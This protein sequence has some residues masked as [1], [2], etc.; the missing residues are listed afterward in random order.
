MNTSALLLSLVLASSGNEL[1]VI[2]EPEL[3][4]SGMGAIAPAALPPGAI[5]A[6]GLLGAPDVQVGYRQGITLVELEAKASFNYLAA[7]FALEVGV[8][9][10]V[11]KRGMLTLAPAISLGLVLN[12]GATYVDARNFGYTG[13]RPRAGL[14]G[15]LAFSEVVSGIFLVELPWTFAFQGGYQATPTAGVGAEFQLTRE[16]SGVVLGQFGVD[17]IKEPVGFAY[18]RPGWAARLGLG[19]RFF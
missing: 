11:Y 19:Y 1:N 14:W 7:S 3:P 17:V 2:S 4:K 6:Y 5:S 8:R 9:M 18:V 13:L 16:L 10:A 12:S 15:S